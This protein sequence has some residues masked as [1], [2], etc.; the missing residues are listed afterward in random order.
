MLGID[1]LDPELL[2]RFMREGKMPNFASLERDGSFRLLQTSVPPQS[3]V[4][5]SNLITGMDPGGHGVFDFIHRD[6]KT[7][8]PDF[9]ISR[10]ESPKNTIRLGDWVIPLSS[11]GPTL[12]RQGKAFWEILDDH[13]IPATL[14]RMPVNYP[15]VK[16]RART[17]AGMGTPDILGTYGIFSFYTNDPRESEGN[18]SGGQVYQVEVRDSQVSAKLFGP[19]NSFRKSKPQTTVDFTVALDPVEPSARIAL[20][21]NKI[22]LREGEWSDWVQLKFPLVPGLESMN[23]ICRFYLKTVRPYFQL[24]VTPINIDP[25]RPAFP[26][27]TPKDYARELWQKIGFYYTQGIAE[28]TKAL[29]N[30]IFNQTEFLEQARMVLAEHSRVFDLELERFH[31][32]LL[33]FYF[34][35][36][37]QTAH[38]F[39]PVLEGDQSRRELPDATQQQRTL[40]VKFFEEMDRM[41]GKAMSKLEG[42]T[43]LMVLSDHGFAPYH[44]SFNLNTWLL[45]NGYINLKDGLRQDTTDIFSGADWSRTRAYGLGLNALYLNMRGRERDG[46][47][48]HGP[49]AQSLL[50]EI[51]SKLKAVQDPIAGK[52]VITRVDKAE[53]VY[54]G[55]NLQSAPDLIIGYNR[56]YRAG[57]ET[58]LGRFSSR[59]LEDNTERWS[60]DHCIDHT[61]V[62]GVLLSNRKLAME[63]PA[64]T[65]IAPTILAEFAL[66]KPKSMKGQSVF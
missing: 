9:S 56:G 61:L 6:P 43:T 52:S 28:D 64:L 26:L 57:W 13:G 24:Y 12:L 1:G 7:M 58:V 25:S 48:Q 30:G 46:I 62:P 39:W 27:S 55:Q 34:S 41:L 14:F 22:L 60:G 3:P 65:D 42:D 17:L 36:L 16:S 47:V 18:R 8:L 31:A 40:L 51:R 19:Y 20:G 59:V 11:S 10:A 4:A 54:S 21:S 63:A 32:G 15:P 44:R 37:D 45:E 2:R 5:W 53:E 29:S 23:G 35:S 66:E 33:F 49:E 38:M 50:E